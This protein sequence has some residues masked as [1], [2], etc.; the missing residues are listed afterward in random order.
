MINWNDYHDRVRNSIAEIRRAN[1]DI[2]RGYR[3]LSLAIQVKAGSARIYSTRARDA[4]KAKSKQ[5][6]DKES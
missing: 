3:S 2:L 1:L 5:L 6:S 4:V